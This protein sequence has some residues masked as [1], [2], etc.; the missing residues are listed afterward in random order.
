MMSNANPQHGGRNLAL[1]TVAAVASTIVVAV[2]MLVVVLDIPA[3]VLRAVQ[4]PVGSLPSVEVKP[5]EPDRQLVCM[6]PALSFGSQGASAVGYGTS[7]DTVVGAN[8]ALTPLVETDVVDGFSLE[9]ALTTTLPGVVSQPL[10]QGDVA[11]TSAQELS[12]PNVRGLAVAECTD[13]STDVWLVGG[14]TTTGRQSAL[15]II[16]PGDVAASVDIEV[17]GASGPITAPLGRG[18]L[19]AP[20]AQRVLSLAGLAPGE[21]SPVIRVK[22]SGVGVVATLHYSIFRGLTA[23]GLSVVSAQPAPSTLRVITGVFTPPEE[24]FGPIRGKEGYADTAALVRLLSPEKNTRANIRVIYAGAVDSVI[25][26]ELIAG[27]TKDLFLDE[28]GTGDIALI[29]SSEEPIVGAVRSSVGND[30]QTDTDWAASVEGVVGSTVFA[31]PAFAQARLSLVNPSNEAITVTLDGR[32][33][34]V[35]AGS[36]VSRPL[37]PGAHELR[38]TGAIYA[39]VSIRGDTL[40][41]SFS[42]HPAPIPQGSVFVTVR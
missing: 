11:A 14:D 36:I 31:V 26:V 2:T 7:T 5:A 24:L 15:S 17:W 19:I 23:D 18:V 29:V 6:G 40:T 32:D 10:E 41:D 27:Q 33:L 3:G 37:S 22:S 28:F 30:A 8:T 42:V 20:G 25:V 16:N 21:V 1:R 39:A 38:A 34:Q 12:N 4:G 35:E 13:P 9:R